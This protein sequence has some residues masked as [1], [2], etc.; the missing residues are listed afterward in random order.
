[1]RSVHGAQI[2]MAESSCQQADLVLRPDIY[3]D[4]WLDYRHPGKFI[5]LGREAA[6][7]QLEE[8]KALV[9]GKEGVHEQQPASEPM[10][11]LI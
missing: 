8:I 7:R 5:A 3:D 6:E 11:A 1:M 9:A 10:A 2:R 4:R